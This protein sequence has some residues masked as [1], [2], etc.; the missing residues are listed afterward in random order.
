MKETTTTRTAES[1]WSEVQVLRKLLAEE[2]EKFQ[3][4]S[5]LIE[6]FTARVEA[7]MAVLTIVG[8]APKGGTRSSAQKT[9]VV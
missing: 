6:A 9:R 3:S 4:A 2:Q 7:L 5:I 8:I 1:L